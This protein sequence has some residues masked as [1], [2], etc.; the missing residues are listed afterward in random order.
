[1]TEIIAEGLEIA[2]P[3][4]YEDDSSYQEMS[5]D[6]KAK[7]SK[8]HKTLGRLAARF[9]RLASNPRRWIVRRVARARARR[10]APATAARAS[11]SGGGSGDPDPE[12]PRPRSLSYS[13]PMSGG[14]L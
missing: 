12:P 14:A 6:L 9:R 2:I 1:M 13:L 10:M 5:A 8:I 11:D 7:I 4:P 3:I